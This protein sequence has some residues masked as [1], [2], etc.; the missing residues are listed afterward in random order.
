MRI[1]SGHIAKACRG[2]FT[3]T[4]PSTTAAKMA[5]GSLI[6]ESPFLTYTLANPET[7]VCE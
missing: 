4:I 5:T 1:K 7:R 6:D 3:A 2:Y